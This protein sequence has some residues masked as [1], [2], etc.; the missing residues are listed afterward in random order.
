MTISPCITQ[1]AWR[2]QMDCSPSIGGSGDGG[3]WSGICYRPWWLL[4]AMGVAYVTA[5]S[6]KGNNR[7]AVRRVVRRRR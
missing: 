5:R 3:A 7:P 6:L 1:Q 4:L 2:P